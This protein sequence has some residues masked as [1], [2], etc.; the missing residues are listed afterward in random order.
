M[1]LQERTDVELTALHFNAGLGLKGAFFANYPNDD[2]HAVWKI[3]RAAYCRLQSSVNGGRQLDLNCIHRRT[4][5]QQQC[6]YEP[7]R[8]QH[9]IRA[10]EHYR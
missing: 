6:E 10:T 8:Y 4:N 5:Q 7:L 1:T 9:D 2:Q 3:A